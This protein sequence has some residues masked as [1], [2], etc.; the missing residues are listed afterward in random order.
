MNHILR[1]SKGFLLVRTPSNP[2]KIH[3]YTFHSQSVSSTHYSK[4]CWFPRMEWSNYC[5]QDHC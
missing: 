4:D 3:T 5:V 2:E 1:N